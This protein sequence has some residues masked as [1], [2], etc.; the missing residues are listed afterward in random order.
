MLYETAVEPNTLGLLKK[1]CQLRELSSFALGGGTNIALQKGHRFSIDLDFFSVKGFETPL[2]YKIITSNFKNTELLFEQNQTMMFLIDNIKVDFILYPF[3]WMQQP[4]VVEGTRLI[5]LNDMIPMKLQ[6]LSNRFAK[7]DFWDIEEL[8]NSY[9]LKE[10]I[11]IFQKKFPNVDS[12]F[13]IH[14][15]T[16]FE[17]ADKEQDPIS[18][19]SKTWEEIKKNLAKTVQLYTAGFL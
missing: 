12:G 8:L 5:R 7:K 15:L 14:S 1:I 19:T 17:P 3:D 6:A 11:E 13:I 4:L 10:M 16:H 9:T 18:L 2:V